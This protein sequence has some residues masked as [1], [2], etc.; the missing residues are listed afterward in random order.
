MS[1]TRNPDDRRVE[2]LV[3]SRRSRAHRHKEVQG[4]VLFDPD[5]QPL[6][7]PDSNGKEPVA[8]HD[9][10]VLPPRGVLER[11][12]FFRFPVTKKKAAQNEP[13]TFN[14]PPEVMDVYDYAER[15]VHSIARP[16]DWGKDPQPVA[17]TPEAEGVG[18]GPA[19]C[20]LPVKPEPA[21]TSC[22][23]CYLIN[24]DNL[25][26]R[27][28]WTAE[29]WN[30]TPGGENLAPA[31]GV[32]D[33]EFEALLAGPRGKVF[34]VRFSGIED[35]EVGDLAAVAPLRESGEPPTAASCE[36]ECIDLGAQVEVWQ[37]LRNGCAMGR[38]AYEEDKEKR[39]VPLVN[40]T[41]LTPTEQPPRRTSYTAQLGSTPRTP[42]EA[43]MSTSGGAK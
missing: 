35:W 41:T 30:D 9:V 43:P 20:T 33:R 37:Q 34:R 3:R 25:N 29:E 40:I 21:S 5:A 8:H 32:D 10:L 18:R 19:F 1:T 27:N 14:D 11:G 12:K 22:G 39:I 28:A 7:K 17:R 13:G 15:M 23:I 42:S 16:Q 6:F 31:P 2:T 26:F 36:I 24:A 4:R 38:V